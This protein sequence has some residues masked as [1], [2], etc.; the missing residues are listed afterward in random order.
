[1]NPILVERAERRILSVRGQRVMLDSDLAKLYGVTTFNLNKAVKRNL[2]RFPLDFM[3]QLTLEEHEILIFQIGISSSGRH[4]GRRNAPHVFT[5]H[6]VAMLSSVLR[7]ER[8]IRVNI[9]IMRAFARLRELLASHRDLA[10]K[11]EELESRYD[12]QFRVVFDAI[13]QL[14]AKPPEPPPPEEPEKGRMGFQQS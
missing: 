3:F 9:A 10:R 11:L 4:G 12:G 6:G 7:S 1:M 8:A 2:G 13:R 14:M 5:E